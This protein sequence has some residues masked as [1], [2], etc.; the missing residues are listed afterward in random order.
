MQHHLVSK[1]SYLISQAAFFFIY[2]LEDLRPMF[3]VR[4][5]APECSL[6]Y[7]RSNRVSTF[8]SFSWICCTSLIKAPCDI[9][10]PG[11]CI[12][13]RCLYDNCFFFSIQGNKTQ[14]QCSSS[15]ANSCHSQTSLSQKMGYKS[16]VLIKM[17]FVPFW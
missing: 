6:I 2:I 14:F 1:F 16:Y 17:K 8:R 5:Q 11:A 7:S 10:L 13:Y 15:A 12:S 3:G 4:F 9:H